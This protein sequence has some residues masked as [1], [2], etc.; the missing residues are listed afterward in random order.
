[1]KIK[2]PFIYSSEVV[3]GRKVNAQTMNFLGVV[4]ADI[5]EVSSFEAPV[6]IHWNETNSANREHHARLIGGN[7][8]VPASKLQRD[9]HKFPASKLADPSML[10]DETA[11]GIA[12]ILEYPIG[13]S[14]WQ[15]IRK[16]TGPRA[17]PPRTSD[18]K[19]T[20]S[21]TEERQR[22]NAEEVANGLVSIDGLLYQRVQEPVIAVSN[23]VYKGAPEVT[24]FIYHGKRSYG[25][26]IDLEESINVFDPLNTKF[27][28]LTDHSEA[29]EAAQSFGV[30]VRNEI[31]GEV[32]I[33]I[34]SA[35]TFDPQFD[36]AVR[37]AEY[38]VEGLKA[39][40][41]LFDRDTIECWMDIRE[42]VR[43]WLQ[44]G[45]REIIEELASDDLPRLFELVARMD[46]GVA[47]AI[48]AGLGDW[49]EGTINVSIFNEG[50]RK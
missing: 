2:L 16:F 37:T 46:Q 21:S 39:R 43:Q 47:S 40:I 18:I 49:G 26:P 1:M 27:F 42:K 12:K 14:D 3:I 15:D 24:V 41:G 34:P 6:A 22:A 9:A 45:D 7:F 31:D 13:R 17:E 36:A 50:L 11:W 48:E 10:D 38:A 20:L 28:A 5:P 35:I 8:Y 4:E 33:V 25:S 32:D 30:N 29:L 23:H 19:K 44:N